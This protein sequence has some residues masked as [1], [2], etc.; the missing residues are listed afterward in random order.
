M[1]IIRLKMTELL[2]LSDNKMISKYIYRF[3]IVKN[4]NSC[5]NK[6][7]KI[8]TGNNPLLFFG[9]SG[10]SV[11]FP[12]IRVFPVSLGTRKYMQRQDEGVLALRC[13]F[14]IVDMI[15][16]TKFSNCP[17]VFKIGVVQQ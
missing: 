16:N 4:K 15:T 14:S 17:N 3:I 8:N 9:L 10:I 2:L 7:C 5:T 1:L 12:V 6:P 13:I 11:V